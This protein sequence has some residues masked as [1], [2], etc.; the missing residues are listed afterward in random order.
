MVGV[1]P[2][3]STAELRA[4]VLGRLQAELEAIYRVDSP[5]VASDFALDREQWAG[6]A[7]HTNV[8][9]L[10]VRERDGELEIGLFV[11]DDVLR[12]VENA[13][14]ERWSHRRVSAHCAAVEGVSHFLY[15]TN[16]ARLPRPVSQLELELQAE[17]D[18][19][20]TILLALW[21]CGRREA[22]SM[23][24]T[25]LFEHVSYRSHLSSA[26]VERYRKANFLA[27]VYCRFLE[28]RYVAQNSVEGFLADLR[29]MYR[30]GAGEKLS[31]AACGAAL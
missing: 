10:L 28:A 8:E 16:R 9:E 31:Y 22:A 14:A 17:I 21:E 23:L 24:R 11:D 26:E 18:K 1:K 7:N 29:R 25:R 3:L 6:H 13:D 20:A 27:S 30:L 4:R 15:L 5:L 19:F 2:S 12:D